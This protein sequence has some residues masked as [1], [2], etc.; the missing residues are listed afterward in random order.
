MMHQSGI[1]GIGV[2]DHAYVELDVKDG[3]DAAE[4][5][6]KLAAAINLPSTSGANVVVGHHRRRR[7]RARRRP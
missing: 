2:T 6:G 7:A 4:A 1:T 5:V 3:A